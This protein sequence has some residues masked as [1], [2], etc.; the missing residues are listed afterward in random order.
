V[1][2]NE[3]LLSLVLPA[4][5]GDLQMNE[6]YAYAAEAPLAIDISAYGGVDDALV[7]ADR[8]KGWSRQTSGRFSY[9]LF[10]GGHFFLTDAR[11]AILAELTAGLV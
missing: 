2:A 4:L 11:D 6:T 3:E 9:R 8:L 5:R 7:D 1:M 10:P